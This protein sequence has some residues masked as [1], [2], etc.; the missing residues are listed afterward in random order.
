MVSII[1]FSINKDGVYEGDS[2][3]QKERLNV[4]FTEARGERY[5]PRAIL[6]DLEPATM[7][8]IRKLDYGA[9]FKPDNFIHGNKGAGNNWAK[10]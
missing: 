9:L 10:G 5:V 1:F 2:P 4:Y 3:L 6:L 8:D 7:D